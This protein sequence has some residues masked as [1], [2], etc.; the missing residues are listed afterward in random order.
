MTMDDTV[1]SMIKRFGSLGLRRCD[2]VNGRL[3]WGYDQGHKF[4]FVP[5]QKYQVSYLNPART[6]HKCA[7]GVYVGS[8]RGRNS[9]KATLEC[10]GKQFKVDALEL[11]PWEGEITQE[12]LKLISPVNKRFH[13]MIDNQPACGCSKSLDIGLGT[14]DMEGFL[15]IPENSRC[16]NC[17]SKAR[18]LNKE[19]QGWATVHAVNMK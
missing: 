3:K 8:R 12:H 15:I 2:I 17:K 6:Q 14:L 7:V 13:L 19:Q 9:C 18:T 5:G 10:M 16:K 4:E 11:V 1:V